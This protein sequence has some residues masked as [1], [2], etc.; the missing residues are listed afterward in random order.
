MY[1][2]IIIL[3]AVLVFNAAESLKPGTITIAGVTLTNYSV[4]QFMNTTAQIWT[5]L[6]SKT[7]AVY[8]TVDMV[9]NITDDTIFF[10]RS[11]M[12]P[13]G[14]WNHRQ[15]K[16]IVQFKEFVMNIML[17]TCQ[18]GKKSLPGTYEILEFADRN[19][20]CGVFYVAPANDLRKGTYAQ[21]WY[22]LRLKYNNKDE[23]F[24]ECLIEFNKKRKEMKQPTNSAYNEG[25][26]SHNKF[27]R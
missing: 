16:G 24:R 23:P 26:C 10:T 17:V 21:G 18:A 12:E 2:A 20:T 19:N 6:T 9:K 3:L 25:M 14:I 13:G 8:C 1:K 4:E 15:C 5:V 27:W 7:P 11:S 22:D